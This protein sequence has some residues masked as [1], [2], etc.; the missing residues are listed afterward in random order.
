MDEDA[1]LLIRHDNAF[2]EPHEDAMRRD[3]TINGLFYDIEP[4]K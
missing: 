4:T 2:G 3:F 1:D